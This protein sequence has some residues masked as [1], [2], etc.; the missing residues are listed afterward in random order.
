MNTT[1]L[2]YTQNHDSRRVD[3]D[4]LAQWPVHSDVCTY[5]CMCVY[6]CVH[7]SRMFNSE[8][9]RSITDDL[10]FHCI[11]YWKCRIHGHVR[12]QYHDVCRQHYAQC[13]LKPPGSK[14]HPDS[15]LFQ[16]S[17]SFIRSWLTVV[18]PRAGAH[19]KSWSPMK[20]E[21]YIKKSVQFSQ[22]RSVLIIVY[23]KYPAEE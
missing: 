6:M 1:H 23:I 3:V 11:D 15:R 8:W 20:G 19:W 7:V 16:A 21:W 10:S 4:D 17:L 14:L 22:S 18:N 13:A 12:M 5:V 9:S 2:W